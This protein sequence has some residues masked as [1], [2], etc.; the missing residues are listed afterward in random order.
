M[1]FSIRIPSHSHLFI[2]S[3][4]ILLHTVLDV[5]AEIQ[6]AAFRAPVVHVHLAACCS[7]YIAALSCRNQSSTGKTVTSFRRLMMTDA[8]HGVRDSTS[9]S[10]AV[11]NCSH[12]LSL[13][14]SLQSDMRCNLMTSFFVVHCSCYFADLSSHHRR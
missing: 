9:S 10:T 3:F 11:C 1:A 14:L 13:S 5:A 8:Q 2:P 7:V 12:T 6:S 4:Y